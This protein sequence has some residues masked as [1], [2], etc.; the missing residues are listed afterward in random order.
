MDNWRNLVIKYVIYYIILI[1][2][3]I[4][5]STVLRYM[6]YLID[7][8]MAIPMVLVISLSL[9]GNI[10]RLY[11]LSRFN[12]NSELMGYLIGRF[13]NSLLFTYLIINNV[14]LILVRYY[15]GSSSLIMNIMG[16]LA[17]IIMGAI[18]WGLRASLLNYFNYDASVKVHQF[19][20]FI[21]ASFALYGVSFIMNIIY[22]PLSY[23][24]IIS[25]IVAFALSFLSLL[26]L[27][28]KGL[29]IEVI[30]NVLKNSRAIIAGFFGIGL[31]Y[32]LIKVPK[33]STWNLYIFALFVIMA[34]SIIAYTGYRAYVSST[35]FIESIEEEVY[36]AHKRNVNLMNAPDLKPLIEAVEEFI[37]HGKKESLLMYLTFM[38]S[39]NGYD[40]E[41][42]QEKLGV[43]INYSSLKEQGVRMRKELI[44]A[45]IRDRINLV[46]ELL[47]QVL[48]NDHPKD[49]EQKPKYR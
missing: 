10:I 20:G 34:S 17:F 45:E 48:S 42:I 43:L 40:F 23:P 9:V 37:K 13:I 14:A 18:I 46:N 11:P 7:E 8:V 47:N 39:N 44:E 27:F 19:I 29:V 31:L 16:F 2:A 26:G 33:P 4:T 22:E 38:L 21:T 15:P 32:S 25:S 30:N 1:V 3:L 49:S 12:L 28:I 35:A 41:E 6:G 5:L 36:E 24:F